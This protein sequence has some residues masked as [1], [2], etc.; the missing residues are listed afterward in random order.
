MSNMETFH[1]AVARILAVHLE[2]HPLPCEIE[3]IANVSSSFPGLSE[4]DQTVY[5]NTVSWLIQEDYLVAKSGEILGR[6]FR[7]GTRLT[8]KGLTLLGIEFTATG[9]APTHKTFGENLLEAIKN[10][11]VDVAK[12]LTKEALLHFARQKLGLV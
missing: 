2:R 5:G 7:S 9:V 3:G 10:N 12:T 4:A 11:A 6:K 1:E 8:T